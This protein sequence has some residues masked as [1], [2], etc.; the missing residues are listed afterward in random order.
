MD[1]HNRIVFI[2]GANRG[3]GR[4]LVE[5]ALERGAKKIYAASR[6]LSSLPLWDDSRVQPIQLDITDAAQAQIAAAT[7]DDTEILINNAGALFGSSITEGSLEDLRHNMEVNYFGTLNVIR[8]FLPSFVSKK[9]GAIATISSIIGLASSPSLGAYSAS[10]AAVTSAIQDLRSRMKNKGIEVYRIF[11]GTIATDMTRAMSMKK[12][13][14]LETVR[15][16]YDGMAAGQPDI[17]PDPASAHLGAIWSKSPK[18]LEKAL[19]G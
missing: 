17:F 19:A 15:S 12:A 6:S 18:D 7:A 2:T 16:I 8:A 9:H 14:V 4:A 1:V 10:K 5:V 11:P 3:I 13:P